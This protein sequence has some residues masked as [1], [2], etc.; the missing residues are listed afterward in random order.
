MKANIIYK[1]HFIKCIDY[2]PTVNQGLANP[3]AITIDKSFPEASSLITE[4]PN[5]ANVEAE[6]QQTHSLRTANPPKNI[7][8]LGKLKEIHVSE[9]RGGPPN[10][11]ILI[12]FSII[13]HPFWGTP[14]FGNT[15]IDDGINGSFSFACPPG[16]QLPIQSHS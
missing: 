3:Q 1:V 13:N 2:L 11:P 15:Q 10:H 5:A 9:N 6:K 12:G 4:S 8:S 16:E 7:C 14:I